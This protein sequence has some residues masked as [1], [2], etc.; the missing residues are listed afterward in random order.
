MDDAATAFAA[1]CAVIAAS[2]GMVLCLAPKNV[3]DAV[4]DEEP[5][6]KEEKEATVEDEAVTTTEEAMKEENSPEPV[7]EEE[8]VISDEPANDEI[9]TTTEALPEQRPDDSAVNDTTSP[10]KKKRRFTLRGDRSHR[11]FEGKSQAR[12][13]FRK[14]QSMKWLP[15]RP[16]NKKSNAVNV[17]Q[18]V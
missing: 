14:A 8:P 7:L 15:F 10:M 11:I 2:T 18:E 17:G 12:P 13:N 6:T 3:N 1:A 16:N 4:V 9:A 5:V